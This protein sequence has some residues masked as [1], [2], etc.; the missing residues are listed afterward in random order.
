M[1]AQKY[2]FITFGNKKYYNSVNRIYCEACNLNIFNVVRGYT[3]EDLLNFK[4]F[5]LH[6]NFVSK[7]SRGFGYWIWKSFLVMKH[8]ETMNENDILVYADSG[9]TINKEGRDRMLEY[10][11]MVNES[12]TANV[13]FELYHEHIERRWNKMDLINYLNADEFKDSVQIVGGIFILRKCDFVCKL[14]REWYEVCCNYSLI[15]DSPSKLP[16]YP[17]FSEHRHDQSVFSLLR[18]KYGCVLLGDETYN[19]YTSNPYEDKTKPIHATR[20]IS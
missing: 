9:C 10:F 17:E 14:I 7:N 13:G 1:E 16:N 20:K 11:K 6:R 4:D 8:L 19:N 12:P 15:D 3:D 2:N 5:N 18:K